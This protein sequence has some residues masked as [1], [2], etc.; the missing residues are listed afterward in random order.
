VVGIPSVDGVSLEADLVA[1]SL[2]DASVRGAV[3]L[4]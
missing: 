4:A 2:A 3:G 1:S